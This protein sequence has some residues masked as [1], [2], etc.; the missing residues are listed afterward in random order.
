MQ[1]DVLKAMDPV[2]LARLN[3]TELL[4]YGSD[5]IEEFI[6]FLKKDLNK[7][8]DLHVLVLW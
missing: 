5:Y 1:L 3:V 7:F 2:E 6:V 4:E 8:K